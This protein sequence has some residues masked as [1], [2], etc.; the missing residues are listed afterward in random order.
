M[1]KKCGGGK[2]KSIELAVMAVFLS[3]VAI[4]L[5]IT[6]VGCGTTAD[7][8]KAVSDDL[9]LGDKTMQG[10]ALVD[11]W[12]ITTTGENGAPVGKKVTVIGKLNSIP[13][14][15]RDNAVVKDY[16]EYQYTETPAW[17][18]S[19]NVTKSETI[20]LTGDNAKQLRAF[21]AAKTKRLEEDA[22][23]AESEKDTAK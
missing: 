4:L 13:M 22:A 2:K 12:K 10:Y 6:L 11:I 5:G 9:S 23:K 19:A 14:T 15:S 3:F 17:Y 20:I 21:M 1:A 7:A 8:V 18:N 16:G